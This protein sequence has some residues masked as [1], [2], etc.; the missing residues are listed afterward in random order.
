MEYDDETGQFVIKAQAV[1]FPM[2]VHEIVKGL[3]EI[4]ST[5]GFGADKAKNQAI[6]GA[7]DKLENEPEDLRYG[8]F[9]YDAITK[10]Y[11]DNT[12]VNDPRIRELFFTEIYK[13][14]D[15]EFFDFIE[16]A[17]NNELTPNQVKWAKNTMKDVESDL[18][19]DDT[20]LEDL[21]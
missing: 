6:V 14:D 5:S 4:V 18:K 3:Y 9:I 16:N 13:M 21:D 8:K 10:L 11:N 12:E 15:S 20:G 19:K 2:L 17:I 7:V 1:C